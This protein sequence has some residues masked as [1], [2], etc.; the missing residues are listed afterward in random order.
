MVCID[1]KQALTF[2]LSS[3]LT[4]LPKGS[5]QICPPC[6]SMPMLIIDGKHIESIVSTSFL[7][8]VVRPGA[9]SSVLA[10]F[11]AMPFAPSSEPYRVYQSM[12]LSALHELASPNSTHLASLCSTQSGTFL[13]PHKT[14]FLHTASQLSVLLVLCLFLCSI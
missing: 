2:I 1:K 10:P 6:L 13:A 8:L 14:K 7:L 3:K 11:V 5:H 12:S 9:P 4:A